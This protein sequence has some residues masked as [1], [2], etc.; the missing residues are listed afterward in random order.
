MSRDRVLFLSP[1]FGAQHQGSFVQTLVGLRRGLEESGITTELWESSSLVGY[2]SSLPR[3][4]GLLAAVFIGPPMGQQWLRMIL[5]SLAHQGIPV[6]WML[7]AN[8]LTLPPS[9]L[10]FLKSYPQIQ[11][12][13]PSAWSAA[14]I[15]N[16]LAHPD[17][18]GFVAPPHQASPLVV[19]H[20]VEVD[21]EAIPPVTEEGMAHCVAGTSGRKGT[22]ELLEAM[23]MLP[24]KRL[25]VYAD[26]T[27][28]LWAREAAADHPN[29]RVAR[30]Y[31]TSTVPA[32]WR[33]DT[34]VQPSRA[35][36][37]G[38]CAVEAWAIGN[39]VVMRRSTG[40][41]ELLGAH[42]LPADGPAWEGGDGPVLHP[43]PGL[44]PLR[45]TKP[46]TLA[47]EIAR[48]LAEP[49]PERPAPYLLEPFRFAVA[50]EPLV[51][52]MHEQRR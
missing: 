19:P 34:Y 23:R 26:A 42:L 1:G 4:A 15:A 32:F 31:D 27:S 38:L 10:G 48:A 28:F 13:T 51:R 36:G 14:V 9:V 44:E 7:A 46:E 16:V 40:E 39:R 41:P 49:P 8:S 5:A 17:V 18:T 11:I 29:V 22:E 43:T 33:H 45:E 12:L 21:P 6:F 50:I 35:E 24:D 37:Y 2:E 52:R 30:A 3:L 47:R 20:G 25:T